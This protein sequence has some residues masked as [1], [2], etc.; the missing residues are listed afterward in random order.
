MAGGDR[1]IHEHP[2]AGKGNFKVNPQNAGRP[3]GTQNSKKRL[4]RLLELSQS[5]KNPVTK[6]L[7]EFT[8]LEQM[9]MALINKALKGDVHAYKDILDRLK[10]DEVDETERDTTEKLTLISLRDTIIEKHYRHFSAGYDWTISMGGSRSGKTYNFVKWALLQ[11][12]FGKFDL[13]IIAPSHKTLELGAFAD[14]RD[15]FTKYVPDVEIPKRPTY[16]EVNGSRWQ[17]EVVTSE[18]E[19]KRN[20]GNV[21]INEADGIPVEVANIIGRASGRKFID[22]NPVKRFWAHKYINED[23]SNLLVSTWQD[24]PYLSANQLQW[25]EDLRKFGENAEQGSPERY[26]Y[27]VYYLGDY[28]LM[29]GK[30]FDIT[31]FDM[32]DE[33]PKCDY[34]ISYSDTSLGDGGDFWATL[35]FGVKGKDI[36]AID[37]IFSQYVKVTGFVE[38]LKEWDKKYLVDHYSEI[39]GVSGISTKAAQAIYDNRIIPVNN[40]D[41]KRGD[42]LVYAPFAK[43]VKF[44]KS[45]SMGLFLAQCANFPNDQHDDAPDCLCRGVKI[46]KKYFDI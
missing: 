44:V 29:G 36:Y 27:D 33:A 35:L 31:D 9:D 45:N 28:S 21:F 37:C 40:T 3:R 26:A 16:I 23:Q 34:Y 46:I 15:I 4:W 42:I 24:N 10:I 43:K 13:S 19:A 11:T 38:K 14:V 7:E 20:R 30:A 2:N 1:K 5:I 8:L 6:E 18:N 22:F 25:F 17:F 32:I 12:Y 39:N 41:N